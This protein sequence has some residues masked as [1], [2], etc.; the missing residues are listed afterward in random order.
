MRLLSFYPAV[1]VNSKLGYFL[2]KVHEGATVSFTNGIPN[3]KDLDL[4]T[5]PPRIKLC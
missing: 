3:S 1:L 2:R 4:A 5:E